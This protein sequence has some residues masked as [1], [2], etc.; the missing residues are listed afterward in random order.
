MMSGSKTLSPPLP[1]DFGKQMLETLND[2]AQTLERKSLRECSQ[3]SL[4]QILEEN[5]ITRMWLQEDLELHGWG[6]EPEQVEELLIGDTEFEVNCP[7]SDH[8]PIPNSLK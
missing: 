4:K 1:R 2:R 8:K 6:T 3:E 7:F 5:N